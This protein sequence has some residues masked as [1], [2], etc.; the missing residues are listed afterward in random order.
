MLADQRRQ[1]ILE[2][3]QRNNSVVI[4][5]LAEKLAVTPMTIRRDLVLLEKQGIVEKTHGGAVLSES[6]IR[7]RT[8]LKR[9]EVRTPE[10]QRIAK[11][12]VRL[13]E[14]GMCICLDAGTTNYELALLLIERKFSE[15]TVITNDLLIAYSLGQNSNYQVLLLG[16]MLE[17]ANGLTCGYFA[18]EMMKNM[19][20]DICFVGTQAVSEELMVMTANIDKVELKQYYLTNAR[21]KVLLADG[22]KFA[23]NKLHKICVLSEFDHV[24]TDNV[25]S[26]EQS[27]YL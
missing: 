19:R 9:K 16:G 26:A 20:V 1:I 5:D 27:A 4:V 6:S 18:K 10:K 13:V 22:S 7:E 12:A 25:F 15:L 8:Y 3:L 17:N 24:I 14:Q 11:A 21:I 23:K 2:E